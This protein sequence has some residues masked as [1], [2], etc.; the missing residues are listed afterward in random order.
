M[1]VDV[2]KVLKNIIFPRIDDPVGSYTPVEVFGLHDDL[3]LYDLEGGLPF[4]RGKME[5]KIFENVVFWPGQSI[6]QKEG[7]FIRDTYIDDKRI[8]IIQE[9]GEL[10]RYP[11]T[12]CKGYATC[13]DYLYSK[14]NY[15]HQLIDALPRVWALRHSKLSGLPITLFLTR[16]ISIDELKILKALLPQN[17]KVRFV[18]RFSR[19]KSDY[20]IHL[21]F[22]SRDRVDY[23]KSTFTS[24]GFIPN[25]YL[26]YYRSLVY[27]IFGISP[28]ENS[29]RIYLTRRFTN[30]RFI[31]NEDSLYDYLKSKKFKIVAPEKLQ[32]KEQVLLFGSAE[33]IVAQMGASLTNLLYSQKGGGLVEINSSLDLPHHFSLHAE[34]LEKKYFSVRLSENSIHSNI[35]LPLN[36]LVEAVE[37]IES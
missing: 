31:L 28:I 15:F 10:R 14:A 16:K 5:I 21:P 33:I 29:E 4:Q 24:A 26:D 19:I 3:T 12:R 35:H 17:I 25:Q 9:Y 34:V 6:A 23:S 30:K 2:K 22:L 1:A 37:Y 32:L 20:Y 27:D 13:I 11:M 36:L 7:V 8:R 18:H